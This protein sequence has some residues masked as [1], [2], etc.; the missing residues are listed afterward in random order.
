[1][2]CEEIV[3]KMDELARE[4]YENHNPEIPEEIYRL[5]SELRELDHDGI[6]KRRQSFVLGL[7]PDR[8]TR[9]Q[10]PYLFC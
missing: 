1:V 6:G 3:Q 10:L 8:F 9:A 5:A 2:T 4:Y 7:L